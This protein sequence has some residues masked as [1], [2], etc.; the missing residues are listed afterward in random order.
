MRKV[1]E[2]ILSAALQGFSTSDCVIFVRDSSS[3]KFTPSFGAG[4]FFEAIK[5]IATIREEERNVCG[6]CLQ[7]LEDVLIYDASDPKI[8]P[9]LPPWIKA[10]KLASFVLL[11]I[12]DN[13]R[14]FAVVLATWPEKKNIG[15]SVA[16]IRHVRSMLRLA[17]TARRLADSRSRF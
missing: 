6:L 9:H 7:R 8:D 10:N 16:Q 4:P 11:P 12:Q 1:Y 2:V 17:G 14:P 3:R 13:R 15:F 5:H